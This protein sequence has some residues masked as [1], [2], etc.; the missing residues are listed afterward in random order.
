MQFSTSLSIDF[1]FLENAAQSG[2]RLIYV[3][4]EERPRGPA[5]SGRRAAKWGWYK[6]TR[7]VGCIA[8]AGDQAQFRI[9][10]SNSGE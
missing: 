4:H 1:K 2:K 6:R 9:R 8:C 3:A 5:A 7:W 10:E